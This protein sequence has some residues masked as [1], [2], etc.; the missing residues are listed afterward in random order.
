MKICS[1][2]G[3]EKSRDQFPRRAGSPDGLRG[4]CRVC[5]SAEKHAYYEKVKQAAGPS[6]KDGT[7]VCTK[8]GEEK[9]VE[10][11]ADH[12]GK[13][14]GL[15]SQCNICVAVR[16]K[17]WREAN[18]ER[19]RERSRVNHKIWWERQ[20]RAQR[21]AQTYG[22]TPEQYD[23]MLAAQGGRCAACAGDFPGRGPHV[24]HDHDTDR[25]RGLLCHGCNVSLGNVGDSVDRLMQLAA[26]LLQHEDM[27][28]MASEGK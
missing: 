26:Y 4:K 16:V 13:R 23:E 24:D 7:K 22:V 15:Q 18:I 11:F 9:P 27:L 6:R 14:D 19:V 28:V 21:R 10:R 1:K 12:A 8:C 2:C 25:V 17:A 5:W 3:V 20:G